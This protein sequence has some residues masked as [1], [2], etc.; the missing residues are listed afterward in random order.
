M[1]ENTDASQIPDL[2]KQMVIE[3]EQDHTIYYW[4]N[5]NYHEIQEPFTWPHWSHTQ[6]WQAP[7][8]INYDSIW[9]PEFV[10]DGMLCD[11]IIRNVLPQE[12][13]RIKIPFDQI[14]GIMRAWDNQAQHLYYD[15]SRFQMPPI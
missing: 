8:F 5:N 1:T 12:R 9:N 7:L 13:E 15:S 4:L 10:D 6:R 11:I 3:I 2:L 14:Y